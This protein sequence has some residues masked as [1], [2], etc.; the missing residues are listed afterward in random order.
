MKRKSFKE[1]RVMKKHEEEHFLKKV[2]L[3]SRANA[4]YNK[5]RFSEAFEVIVKAVEIVKHEIE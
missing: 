4:L 3:L 2:G 1:K 5:E